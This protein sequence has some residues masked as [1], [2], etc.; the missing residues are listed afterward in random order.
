MRMRMTRVRGACIRS[1][2]HAIERLS[3]GGSRGFD[4]R[5]VVAQPAK[6]TV[7]RDRSAR[8]SRARYLSPCRG[9]AALAIPRPRR[10]RRISMGIDGNA[11]RRG[12]ALSRED[13]SHW[14]TCV[15]VSV[16]LYVY[17]NVCVRACLYGLRAHEFMCAFVGASIPRSPHGKRGTGVVCA[18]VC[19]GGPSAV[20]VFTRRAVRARVTRNC[21]RARDRSRFLRASE[22]AKIPPFSGTRRPSIAMRG[23]PARVRTLLAV[24]SHRIS[25]F[26]PYFRKIGRAS[27]VA[28]FPAGKRMSCALY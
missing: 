3:F 10:Y 22:R 24:L 5:T 17:G 21:A 27:V 6:A 7:V 26:S 1:V 28:A 8:G 2:L 9:R 11:G 14:A 20:V 19:G 16:F 13:Y 18:C 12:S 15:C 23:S 4:G 25:P